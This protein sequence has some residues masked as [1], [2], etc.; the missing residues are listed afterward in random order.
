M[1]SHKSGLNSEAGA[2]SGFVKD[3]APLPISIIAF[4]K[5]VN[6]GYRTNYWRLLGP[7]FAHAPIGPGRTRSEAGHSFIGFVRIL[8]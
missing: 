1:P 3:S 4:T 6:D 8:C 5:Q 2:P 7:V